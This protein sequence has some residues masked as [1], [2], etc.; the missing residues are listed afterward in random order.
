[1][2]LLYIDPQETEI[3]FNFEN[4]MAYNLN[5]Q[6]LKW[7]LKKYSDPSKGKF[8]NFMR[9]LERYMLV[10]D[11]PNRTRTFILGHYLKPGSLA[12]S[13]FEKQLNEQQYVRYEKVVQALKD[14]FD[15]EKTAELDALKFMSIKQ[16]PAENVTAYLMRLTEP[17]GDEIPENMESLIKAKFKKGLRK[18]IKRA[19]ISCDDLNLQG[20][21]KKARNIERELESS[22]ESS[23]SSDST[24]SSSEDSDSE[25]EKRK[26]NKKK[27]S[28]KGKKSKDNKEL[29]K[30]K[31]LLSQ[32]TLDKAQKDMTQPSIHTNQAVPQAHQ[33]PAVTSLS[34]PPS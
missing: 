25:Y 27:K 22:S 24:S 18:D 4:N 30:I 32:V 31:K 3:L 19:L 34:H 6:W 33:S 20:L 2:N 13:I 17:F 15:N 28:K 14:E 23:S 16:K 10:F 1:M 9:N 5:A 8:K 21:A 12:K 26:K 11:I 7:D 29:T